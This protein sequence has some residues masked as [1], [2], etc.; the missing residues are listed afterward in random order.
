MYRV[1]ALGIESHRHRQFAS[2]VFIDQPILD[3]VADVVND[4]ANHRQLSG[5]M[6]LF[7]VRYR[8]R[9]SAP[10]DLRLWHRSQ[11]LQ[12]NLHLSSTRAG[13]GGGLQYAATIEIDAPR[14]PSVGDGA[15][16]AQDVVISQ[17]APRRLIMA[18]SSY[19]SRRY[20]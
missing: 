6:S 10:S 7:E 19:A 16:V 11:R 18:R 8:R 20:V 3:A 5:F 14:Y 12:R 15:V 1:L 2:R 17:L 9:C 13:S 4:I